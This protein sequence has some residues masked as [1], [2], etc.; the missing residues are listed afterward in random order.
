VPALLAYSCYSYSS[1]AP[2]YGVTNNAASAGYQWVMTNVLPQ[3]LGLT[4]GNVIYKYTTEKERADAMLVHVQNENARGSGYIF[5]ETDD[6]SGVDGNTISK[7]VPVPDIDIS[8]WGV[9]S[10]EV[11]GT[12]TVLD[13]EVFYTYKY[14]PCEDQQSDPECPGYIDPMAAVAIAEV[15]MSQESDE[16]IQ[17]EMDRKANLKS[18][19]EDEE[20]KEREKTLSKEEIEE[21]LEKLLGVINTDL[22]AQEAQALHDALASINYLPTSYLKQ[23]NGGEYRDARR[24][25]DAKLPNNNRGARVGLAQQVLHEKMVQSQYQK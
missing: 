9:G 16:Y 24:L 22:M 11:E 1:E 14:T 8:F 15:I 23:V 25:Q 4:V 3:Q 18:Q 20:K 19:K 10:I 21:R 7:I 2:V 5:R 6:W 12:G 17:D 13:P